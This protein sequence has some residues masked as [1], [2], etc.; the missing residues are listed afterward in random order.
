[1][2]HD[3]IFVNK[4]SSSAQIDALGVGSKMKGSLL[5][6]YYAL[7][8]FLTRIVFHKGSSNS[9][10]DMFEHKSL[11]YVMVIETYP[12]SVIKHFSYYI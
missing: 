4:L 8:K 7:S 2:Q 10:S 6:I 11:K 12:N 5:C 9:F 1:M 3:F